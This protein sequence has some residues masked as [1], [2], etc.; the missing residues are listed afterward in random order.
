[1][2][3]FYRCSLSNISRGRGQSSVASAAYRSGEELYDERAD[4]SFDYRNKSGVVASIIIFPNGEY[5]LD[6]ELLWNRVEDFEVRKDARLAREVQLGLPRELSELQR[7]NVVNIF[8]RE[9]FTDHGYIADINIH[10]PVSRNDNVEQPHAHIMITERVYKDGTFLSKKDRAI[11][12]KEYLIDMRKSWENCLNKALKD[13]QIEKTVDCRT[14][15][16]Q[17]EEAFATQDYE[18]AIEFTRDPID[19]I[20]NKNYLVEVKK[21]NHK[22]VERLKNQYYSQDNEVLRIS[23][24]RKSIDEFDSWLEGSKETAFGYL[25]NHDDVMDKIN[26]AL[27]LV[28]TENSQERKISK[29]KKLKFKPL[30]RFKLFFSNKY[31]FNGGLALE[32]QKNDLLFTIKTEIEKLEAVKKTFKLG[33]L[34][35]QSERLA[36]QQYIENKIKWQQ[37]N[38]DRL[39]L[40]ETKL[41]E[42]SGIGRKVCAEVLEY[43]KTKN[44]LDKNQDLIA[45]RKQVVRSHMDMIRVKNFEIEK[46]NGSELNAANVGLKQ[47]LAMCYKDDIK[48]SDLL[49][50]YTGKYGAVRV[51][52]ILSN[53]PEILGELHGSKILK[54][55]ERKQ[56]KGNIGRLSNSIISKHKTLTK[57]D[58]LESNHSQL[59]RGFEKVFGNVD[60]YQ[61]ATNQLKT[62][63]HEVLYKAREVSVRS[64]NN[65]ANILVGRSA[66]VVSHSGYSAS[67]KE[68]LLDKTYER[69][70]EKS[71]HEAE[72]LKLMLEETRNS[73]T[74]ISRKKHRSDE[75]QKHRKQARKKAVSLKARGKDRDQGMER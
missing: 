50:G 19:D 35:L 41:F 34:Q 31:E 52:N 4:K 5:G 18:K 22:T 49:D 44:A 63:K 40:K 17:R 68:Q 14:L 28:E 24:L 66:Y 42:R 61:K 29:Q 47:S 73:Q 15:V 3:A 67:E 16:D 32:P 59:E 48:A 23:E 8:T 55:Q 33:E 64:L 62:G 2:Q 70:I 36:K 75:F 69:M 46:L 6:R 1:M 11:Q 12:S 26:Y 53:K 60:D 57:I 72:A 71:P 51:A 56:A 25:S 20:R 65:E 43:R 21:S 10:N 45:H 30:Q 54:Y 37:H 39:A 58:L 9:N 7:E 38:K 13:A 74:E 27:E